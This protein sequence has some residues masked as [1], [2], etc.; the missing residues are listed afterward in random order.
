M[1]EAGAA[2]PMNAGPASAFRDSNPIARQST[3][4][5]PVV[6]PEHWLAHE[7]LDGLIGLEIGAASHNPFGLSTRNVA[8]SEGSD[9]YA[10]EQRARGVGPAPVDIWA[11][12][13][14]I[15]VPDRSEDF[16]LSSHVLEH[17]PNVIGAFLEWDRIVREGGYV[18]LI[19]PLH[20]AL[21]QDLGRELTPLAHF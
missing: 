11:L 7:L 21:P 8:S 4:S 10:E 15:P 2:S 20:G 18:F 1:R 5:A 3:S 9:F 16:I 12:G 17:L 6:F 14:R 13:D 19:V